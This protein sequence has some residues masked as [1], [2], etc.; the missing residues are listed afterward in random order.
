[1]WGVAF[2]IR[3]RILSRPLRDVWT[4]RPSMGHSDSTNPVEQM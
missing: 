2:A 1:M 3:R 4:A